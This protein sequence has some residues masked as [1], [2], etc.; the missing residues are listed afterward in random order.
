[1]KII[2]HLVKKE[3]LQIL[4]SKFM[5]ALM[6]GVPVIQ[7]ILLSF[8]ANYDIKNLKV[9]MV[10]ND[11]SPSSRLIATTLQGSSFFD[12]KGYTFSQKE[13]FDA[14]SKDKADIIIEIPHHFERDLV[15][16]N[17]ASVQ[18]LINAINN[19]KAGL[20]N[21]YVQAVLQDVNANIRS[22]WKTAP[23]LNSTGQ[24]E[25]VSVN[26]YNPT[27]DYPTLMVPGI[28][29][30]LLS[31]L[32]IIL[33]AL[34]IVKEK[35][36]GTLEQIN[37]TPVTKFQFIL[38]KLLPF[39]VIGHIIFWTGLSVGKMV[40]GIPI[41]GSLLVI[42][43]FLS[44]YLFVVLGIGLFISNMA[45]TQQQAMFVAFFFIMAF[46]LLCG[47]FTP[48]EN[49]PQWAQWLN[50]INPLYYFVEVNR[51]VIIKGSGLKIIA[52]FIGYMAIYA[53]GING[54]AIWRYK[55]TT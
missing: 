6:T 10:D 21:G 31:L 35:E 43:A 13:A 19:T 1:M 47:L 36:I 23:Q 39:W 46:I 45:E 41:L 42:E 54:L 5:I 37:V 22:E 4:R 33:T 8:A 40:F 9:Y 24:I 29:A 50:I 38:G 2:F 16:E 25:V 34:N 7:L 14:L 20:A 51:L 32:T 48:A 49:M 26:W 27:L 18:V 12:F 52:P 28:L 30:E 44:V 11:L 55:K 15:K 3:F 17:N 53:I